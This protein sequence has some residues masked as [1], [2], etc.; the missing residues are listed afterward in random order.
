MGKIRFVIQNVF[1]FIGVIASAL[2]LENVGFLT[3]APTGKLPNP[4]FYIIFAIVLLSYFGL[5]FIEYKY[6]KLKTDKVILICSILFILSAIVGL[7]TFKEVSFTGS[8]GTFVASTTSEELGK[9]F[10]STFTFAVTLYTLIYVFSK[11]SASYRKFWIVYLIVIGVGYF[12]CIYSLVV[13][14]DKYVLFFEKGGIDVASI[15]SLYWNENM[16]GGMLIMGAV[17]CILLNT[18]KRNVVSYVSIIFFT[19]ISLFVGSVSSVTALIVLSFIYFLIEII[20]KIKK[21]TRSFSFLLAIYLLVTIGCTILFI[22]SIDHNIRFISSIAHYVKRLFTQP[23]YSTFSQRFTTWKTLGRVLI[24]NPVHLIF[25]Y[26]KDIASNIIFTYSSSFYADMVSAHNGFV[27]ALF[28]YG[29]IGLLPYLFFIGYFFHSGFKLLKKKPRFALTLILC[30]ILMLCYSMTES[31]LMFLP[32]TQGLLVGTFFYL[33]LMM[34]CKRERHKELVVELDNQKAHKVN[35]MN[36]VSLCT[37]VLLIV[38]FSVSSLFGVEY[39]YSSAKYFRYLIAV[40]IVLFL[41]LFTLPVL[42]G[43]WTKKGRALQQIFRI[44]INCLIIVGIL[45][46]GILLI[47][48]KFGLNYKFYLIIPACYV[49]IYFIELLIY[50]NW[51]KSLVRK[52]YATLLKTIARNFL[53]IIISTTV[54]TFI[55]LFLDKYFIYGKLIYILLFSLNLVLS[56]LLVVLFKTKTMKEFNELYLCNYIVRTKKAILKENKGKLYER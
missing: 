56:S 33:P 5:Y 1:L 50:G 27:E 17:S 47:Y 30:G 18:I 32:N 38:L 11:N 10:I 2:L 35:K 16:F 37:L 34:T 8:A 45:G 20:S 54:I 14:H 6:N 4:Y 39:V 53:P 22:F 55:G 3:T 21:H 31:V 51:S 29:I 15:H 49:L 36:L 13:E 41:M 40:V 12:S 48:K 42:I 44:A 7:S 52:S 9:S 24:D 28:T 43:V 46:S 19:C 23:N 25:G 26:G